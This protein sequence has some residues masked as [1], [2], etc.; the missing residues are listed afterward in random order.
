M[1]QSSLHR[2]VATGRKRETF[3]AEAE[4]RSI[5]SICIRPEGNGMAGRSDRN[6]GQSTV[7]ETAAELDQLAAE[8]G[9]EE[10]A[11]RAVT[12]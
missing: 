1:R 2:Y 4:E 5:P 9:C 11:L 7:G 12:I 8:I 6:R 10:D 3:V